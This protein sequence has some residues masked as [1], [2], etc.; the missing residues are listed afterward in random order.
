MTAN[1]ISPLS[2]V[3]QAPAVHA[4]IA[5]LTPLDPVRV[6]RQHIRL[7]VAVLI[8]GLIAG[9]ALAFTLEKV[10]PEFTSDAYLEVSGGPVAPYES[11]TA[12]GGIGQH[13]LEVIAAFIRNQVVLI[14]SD[15]VITSVLN[16]DDVKATPWYRSHSNNIER[17]EDL[18]ER[19]EVG[20]V[21][22]S[23]AIRIALTDHHEE[24]LQ[25]IID[26]T[27]AEYLQEYK[28]YVEQTTTG[29]RR[30][31]E[32]QSKRADMEVQQAQRRLDQFLE[33]NDLPT[34]EAHSNEASI[35]Y[36]DLAHD[37][38]RAVVQLQRARSVYDALIEQSKTGQYS[39]EAVNSLE[40]EQVIQNARY[41]LRQVREQHEAF[42]L[43]F[44]PEH[45]IVQDMASRVASVEQ[46]L[47]EATE[48]LLAQR[49]HAVL[50]QAANTVAAM[51][52]QVA[53][54]A[55]KLREARVAVR[56]IVLQIEQYRRLKADAEAATKKGDRADEWL[57]QSQIMR[58]RADSA[59]VREL[60][61]ASSP[62]LTFPNFPGTVVGVAIVFELLAVG[63][64]FVKE[65]LDQRIKSPSDLKL[66][67]RVNIIGML[68]EADE[69]PLGATQIENV[70]HRDPA[71]LM[72][73][74]F[75]QTRTGMLTQIT[76]GGL[77]TIMVVGAQPR[78][79]VSSVINN[80]AISLSLDGRKVL[81][82][83]A[84]FRRPMQHVLFT[85]RGEPGLVEVLKGQATFES[86]VVRLSD[87]NLDVLST[88]GG[89]N[90][91]SELLEGAAFQ[92][93]LAHV[94]S[95]YDAVLID[96]PPTLLTSESLM[97]ARQVNGVVCVVRA[98]RDK[99]GMVGR[100]LRELEA[101]DANVL[102]VVLNGVQ[103]SAGGYFRKNYAEFY[104]YRTEAG[105][106]EQEP[107]YAGGQ[108][109]DE[110]MDDDEPRA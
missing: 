2:P 89:Q 57:Y 7:L 107:Q 61:K 73:E 81:V 4:G 99:R 91:A 87:P 83:D 5:R 66:I 68:P 84:N 102:G 18:Q 19:L 67:P 20:R 13:R 26:A 104:R 24:G 110:P 42:T 78:S 11:Q 108:V 90:A 30:T 60:A 98:S 105:Y 79:G 88:G 100:M 101:A 76:R 40:N 1:P 50:S 43:R 63:L 22:G 97:L 95:Q 75:R 51:E 55:P 41:R 29:V 45:R 12:T 21:I 92:K 27:L 39:A 14:K 53:A 85:T 34:L 32:D 62:K 3:A 16:R 106:V 56:E 58:E 71:G 31:F 72:S 80:L 6:L 82:I 64:V 23:T 25:T 9:V 15:G 103:A 47:A 86:A 77:K 36:Q 46:E 49:H 65:L 37:F 74:A 8:V 10:A 52:A 96:A 38:T 69:D 59:G 17:R 44:G 70:V 28:N 109:D 54:L 94:S 48:R 33:M 35:N 93:L